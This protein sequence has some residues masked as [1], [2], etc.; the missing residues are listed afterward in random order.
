MINKKS[1]FKVMYIAGWYPSQDNPNAGIFVKEHVKSIALYN[2]VTVLYASS[3]RIKGLIKINNIKDN[4]ENLEEFELCINSVLPSPIVKFLKLAG[5]VYLAI[6]L[7]RNGYKPDLINICSIFSVVG[8]AGF[9]VSKFFNLPVITNEHWSGYMRKNPLFLNIAIKTLGS[10]LLKKVTIICPVS[11]YLGNALISLGIK[12]EKIFV[13]PNVVK[14]SY[15]QMRNKEVINSRKVLLFIGLGFGVK[16]LYYL[17]DAL[18]LVKTK[19][20]DFFLEVIGGINTEELYSY[21]EIVKNLGLEEH[22]SFLGVKTREEIDRY[23]EECDFGVQPSLFETFGISILEFLGKGKPV[24]SSDIPPINELIPEKYG[25]L[26]PPR[27]VEALSKAIDIM[28][29]SYYSYP[30]LE[31]IKYIRDNFSYESIGHLFDEVYSM[32]TGKICESS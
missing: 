23:M 22:I 7:V 25:I 12:K 16:G 20:N 28:L 24:I 5:I 13:I 18:R 19:R 6:N 29:D 2:E 8:V 11:N 3:R 15:F 9:L 27:D 17:L 26:V 31:M 14:S 21:K 10:F 30:S 1:K 32:A 4:I